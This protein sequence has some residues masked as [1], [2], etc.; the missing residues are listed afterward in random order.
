MENQK[1]EWWQDK[2]DAWLLATAGIFLIAYGVPILF[3]SVPPWL[4]RT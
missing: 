1:L 2:T 4:D 3:S